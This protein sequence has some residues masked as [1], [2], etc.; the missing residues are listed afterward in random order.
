MK[1]IFNLKYDK[2]SHL[3]TIWVK[4]F[5]NKPMCI[6]R[7]PRETSENFENLYI[8]S[9]FLM[10]FQLKLSD[11]LAVASENWNKVKH[12][13]KI[14]FLGGGKNKFW[15]GKIPSRPPPGDATA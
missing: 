7:K 10:H 12:L 9:I 1:L 11:F 6:E 4:L 3:L 15:W 5:L 14:F 8:K 2:V 13:K